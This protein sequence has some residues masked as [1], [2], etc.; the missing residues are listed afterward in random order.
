MLGRVLNTKSL[1]KQTDFR[2]LMDAW[3]RNLM[4]PSGFRK[5]PMACN[6]LTISY[7]NKLTIFSETSHSK[8]S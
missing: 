5:R 7:I 4:G 1:R 3:F 6:E 8:F 2:N